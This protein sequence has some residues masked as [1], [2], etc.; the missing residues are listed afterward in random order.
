[1]KSACVA[2]AVL[3][4]AANE[5]SPAIHQLMFDHFKTKYGKKYNGDV[6]RDIELAPDATRALQRTLTTFHQCVYD[7]QPRAG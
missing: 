3:V 2:A 6:S 1:M 5:R 7:R 4:T